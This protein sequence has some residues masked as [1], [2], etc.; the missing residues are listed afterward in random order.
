MNVVE[1]VWG[2]GFS[3]PLSGGLEFHPLAAAATS[4]SPPSPPC[5]L[6]IASFPCYDLSIAGAL[7]GLNGKQ[8]VTS[9]VLIKILR[10]IGEGRSLKA[11]H[12]TLPWL[13]GRCLIGE[14]RSLKAIHI[15]AGG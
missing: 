15:I 14:G 9:W 12:I 6:S 4:P 1:A 8:S 2:Q 10:D 7:A 11:I 3:I 5:T 13:T